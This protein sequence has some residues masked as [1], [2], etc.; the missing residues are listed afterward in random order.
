MHNA[1]AQVSS[2]EINIAFQTSYTVS[3]VESLDLC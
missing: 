2:N 1:Y 3:G